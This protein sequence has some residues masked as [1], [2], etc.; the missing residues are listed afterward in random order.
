MTT[1]FALHAASRVKLSLAFVPPAFLGL[2]GF[3]LICS[4]A[5]ISLSAPLLVSGVVIMALIM[6]PAFEM[7]RFGKG[8]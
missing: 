7:Q 6:E 2:P 4:Q 3:S 8:C 5:A 1:K